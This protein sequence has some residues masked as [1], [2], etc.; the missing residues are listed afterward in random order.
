MCVT[1]S[2]LDFAFYQNKLLPATGILDLSCKYVWSVYSL[3]HAEE[4]SSI[5]KLSPLSFNHLRVPYSQREVSCTLELEH[6]VILF[7]SLKISL[8]YSFSPSTTLQ[9]CIDIAENKTRV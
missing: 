2:L 7:L 1:L 4:M 9:S 6:E 8:L 5:I 3:V